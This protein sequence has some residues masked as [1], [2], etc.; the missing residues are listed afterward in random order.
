MISVV[1][2][3]C[4]V[5]KNRIARFY[6]LDVPVFIVLLTKPDDLISQIG[7]SDFDRLSICLSN[8]ICCDSIV[9]CII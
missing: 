1:L 7:L 6:K 2:L 9:M 3:I 5:C 8:F 4:Y